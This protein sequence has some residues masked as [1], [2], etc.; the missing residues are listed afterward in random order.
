MVQQSHTV[1]FRRKAEKTF[2]WLGTSGGSAVDLT[3]RK[4]VHETD[5]AWSPDGSSIVFDAFYY[6]SGSI[7]SMNRDGSGLHDITDTTSLQDPFLP[8]WSPDGNTIAFMN[9]DTIGTVTFS[10]HI[11]APDGSR[12]VLLDQQLKFFYP[13][14]WSPD[15]RKIAYAK[16][17]LGGNMPTGFHIIDV[18]TL[19]AQQISFDDV[20]ILP[21]NF[22]WLSSNSLVCVGT[23]SAGGGV[24]LVST[25]PSLNQ[26]RLASGFKS[27][28]TITVSPDGKCVAMFGALNND[29]GLVLYTE[30]IDGTNFRKLKIMDQTVGCMLI[31]IMSRGQ[32]KK[33]LYHEKGY[34]YFS[35]SL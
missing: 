17:V 20:S 21:S 23:D 15:S 32:D 2:T 30:Q 16:P 8:R 28:P 31:R 6:Q 9:Q 13:P 19:Q 27:P 11:I 14:L 34:N 33:E 12:R 25:Y 22:I 10:L 24:F 5:P 7:C 3:H 4:L 29:S 1:Q 18:A 35:S 26:K